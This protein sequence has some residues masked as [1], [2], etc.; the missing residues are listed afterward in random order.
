MY[1]ERNISPVETTSLTNNLSRDSRFGG[2]F[3]EVLQRTLSSKSNSRP[4]KL[5]LTGLLIPCHKESFGR[6]FKFKLGTESNEYFLAMNSKLAQVAK[7]AAWEEVTVRGQLDLESNV[8]EVEKLTLT[9]TEEP[10]QVPTSFKEPLD[11]DAYERII[12]QRGKLEPAIEY[13]A[14][15]GGVGVELVFETF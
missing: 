1:V 11:I 8:F 14:S 9:Q 13:L 6:V 3:H 7:N 2:T 15:V 4:P 5:E 12:S 10:I